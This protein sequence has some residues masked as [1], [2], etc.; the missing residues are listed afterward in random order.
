MN[1]KI[2]IIII[3]AVSALIL[4]GSYLLYQRYYGG[5]AKFD[6]ETSPVVSYEYRKAA[7]DRGIVSDYLWMRTKELMLGKDGDSLFIPSSYMIAGRLSYQE[8]ESSGEY[9]LSDQALLLTMYV[10]SGD[11]IAA[12]RLKDAILSEFD[13]GS[14]SNSEI[15]AFLS[16]YLYYYT[17]YGSVNDGDRIREI[18]GVL[19]DEEGNMRTEVLEVA[20]YEQGVFYSTDEITEDG[21]YSSLEQGTDQQDIEFTETEGIRISSVDLRLIR[22]LENNGLLPEGSYERNLE[23]VLGSVVSASIPLYAYAYADGIYIYSHDVP[24]AIDVEEAVLTMRHLSEVG[25]LPEDSYSWLKMQFVNGGYI[26]SEYYYTYGSTQGA[27]ASDIYPDVMMIALEL[28]DDDLYDIMSGVEGSRV[29]T[30]SSSPA[31]SM[32]YREENGRFVFYARENLLVCLAVT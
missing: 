16:A 32:I 20:S 5:A 8:A 3:S 4:G 11:R 28:G 9:R 18:T 15:A 1:K 21:S 6:I 30:Y 14:E 24:A 27:Q 12:I 2:L 10:R 29:A 19:F 17:A 23:L 13:I 31:L 22:N 7:S 26:N 25:E